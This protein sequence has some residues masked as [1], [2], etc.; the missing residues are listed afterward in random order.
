MTRFAKFL[1]VVVCIAPLLL[2]GVAA[3]QEYADDYNAGDDYNNN[4][5]NDDGN[6]AND[7]GNAAGDD[8]LDA[9]YYDNIYSSGEFSAG[10]DTITYW[11]DYAILPKKCIVQ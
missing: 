11:T 7:D 2:L 9:Y 1:S 3:E 4:A 5:A 8:A 10:D 6:A